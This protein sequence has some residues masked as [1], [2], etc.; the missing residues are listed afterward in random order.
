MIIMTRRSSIPLDDDSIQ[1]VLCYLPDFSSLQSALL[2]CR[3]IYR[4]WRA[5]PVQIEYAIAANIVGGALPQA[6]RLTR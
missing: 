4:V 1:L 6:L 3:A 2:S 5:Y